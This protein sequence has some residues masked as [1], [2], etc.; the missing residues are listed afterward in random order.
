MFIELKA[1]EIRTESS[2][3]AVS[4]GRNADGGDDLEASWNQELLDHTRCEEEGRGGFGCA[5]SRI[6]VEDSEV[7]RM[8]P[9]ES[10]VQHN[11]VVGY[12]KRLTA[13]GLPPQTR[14]QRLAAEDSSP[15]A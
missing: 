10:R 9:V 13:E 12:G 5:A 11:G 6:Q 4:N 2:E 14:R 7:N 8:M 15:K 1:I 3:S